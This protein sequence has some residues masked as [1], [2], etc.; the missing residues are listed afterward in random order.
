MTN[1]SSIRG[2]GIVARVLHESS[3]KQEP[4]QKA[5]GVCPPE[6]TRY[7]QSPVPEALQLFLL[8]F[9]AQDANSSRTLAQGSKEP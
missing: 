8:T 1:S 4:E 3:F 5:E 7:R 6:G 2:G 9:V